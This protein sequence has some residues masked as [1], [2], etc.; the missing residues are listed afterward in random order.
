[1]ASYVTCPYGG[2]NTEEVIKKESHSATMPWVVGE[3]I[4]DRNGFCL[5]MTSRCP[6]WHGGHHGMARDTTL[7]KLSVVYLRAVPDEEL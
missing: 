1:M 7:G 2:C 4:V 3:Q 6:P 5:A